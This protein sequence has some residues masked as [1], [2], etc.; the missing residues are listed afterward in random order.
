LEPI[1]I[2]LLEFT[3]SLKFD[4]D[5]DLFVSYCHLDSLEVFRRVLGQRENAATEISQKIQLSVAIFLPDLRK[6][7]VTAASLPDRNWRLNHKDEKVAIESQTEAAA[8]WISVD[9]ITNLEIGVQPLSFLKR[10]E[11]PHTIG[12]GRS[13]TVMELVDFVANEYR[14]EEGFLPFEVKY[15]CGLNRW[16]WVMIPERL[17]SLCDEPQCKFRDLVIQLKA[18]DRYRPVGAINYRIDAV[19][20]RSI[21]RILPK[22]HF[23]PYIFHCI[24]MMIGTMKILKK[25]KFHQTLDFGRFGTDYWEYLDAVLVGFLAKQ[26][27]DALDGVMLFAPE[28]RRKRSVRSGSTTP[29]RPPQ[30]MGRSYEDQ[31]TPQPKR[32]RE[33]SQEHER[34]TRRFSPS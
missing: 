28:D 29:L 23:V 21:L 12:D 25:G 9:W 30:G 6:L 15:V 8:E 11:L 5:L 24:G 18:F 20:G 1:E 4:S 10:K 16:Q 19:N 31:H 14:M 13:F 26:H 17:G 27:L 2:P 3:T 33:R 32:S 7:R 34:S 22:T